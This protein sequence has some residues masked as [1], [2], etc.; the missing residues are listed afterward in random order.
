MKCS[1]D[2]RSLV[3]QNRLNFIPPTSRMTNY[4]V[5]KFGELSDSNDVSLLHFSLISSD[6]GSDLVSF[7]NKERDNK[8]LSTD[9]IILYLLPL[10]AFY[11]HFLYLPEK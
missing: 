5:F 4:V 10:P 8:T 2:L 9:G 6:F 11:L 7:L 1:V 3:E